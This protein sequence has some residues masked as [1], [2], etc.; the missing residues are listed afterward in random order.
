MEIFQHMARDKCV[1]AGKIRLFSENRRCSPGFV[2]KIV[3]TLTVD[4]WLPGGKGGEGEG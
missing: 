3:P 1:I 4:L 2:L